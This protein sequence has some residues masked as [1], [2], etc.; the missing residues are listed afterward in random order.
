VGPLV[1]KALSLETQWLNSDTRPASLESGCYDEHGNPIAKGKGVFK[2]E[3]GPEG[4]VLG[5]IDPAAEPGQCAQ[6]YPIYGNARIQAG[7]KIGK[8][9]LKCSLKP[10]N[11]ALH[12]GTYGS[13]RFTEKQQLRL[14]QT[15]PHGVCDYSK[16]G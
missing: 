2:G 9:I 5:G 4:H 1:L 8:H 6:A 10:V 11:V 14:A 15:F 13:V 12:D 7:R 3:V 16:P